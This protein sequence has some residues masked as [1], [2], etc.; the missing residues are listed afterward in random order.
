MAKSQKRSPAAIAQELAGSLDLSDSSFVSAE[1]AGPYV[2]LRL[3]RNRLINR[4]LSEEPVFEQR[5]GTV[6]VDYSAPNIAKPIGIGHLRSTVIGG[7]LVRIFRRLGMTV[8]GVN[9]LGDW[10]T[11]FG[12]LI[13]A[14]RKW[15][16]EEELA[17]APIKHLH[18][19][20]VRFHKEAE[21]DETLEQ[22]GRDAFKQLED[23]NADCRTLW[24]RFR[25]ASLVE[26]EK[27][28]RQLGVSF[29]V[30]TGEAAYQDK[31]Q[32]AIAACAGIASESDGALVV[33]LDG[34][35]PLL[36]R[37][38]DGATLYATRDLAAALDR[39]ATYHPDSLLYVVGQEQQLHFAQL[40][41]VLG[42][43]G[44]DGVGEHVS[45]GLYRFADGKMSTR[46]GKSVLMEDVL[47]KAVAL[48]REV[49]EQKNPSLADKETVA[50]QVG[51]GAVIF[52]DLS[53]DRARDVVFDWDKVLDFS[54]ESGPY[55][56]YTHARIRSVLRKAGS[57]GAVGDASLGEEEFRLARLLAAFPSRVTEA[58]DARKP[59][60][61]CRYLL[62]LCQQYNQ[63]YQNVRIIGSEQEQ[64]RLAL[65]AKTADVLAQGLSL[66]GIA[67]PE[68]M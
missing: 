26:F 18:A 12:K 2:N 10:G 4:V 58:A 3:D 67:A 8:V 31:A 54:G 14:W 46:K 49:I 13:V 45:F 23:G 22:Q 53:T 33:E 27:T 28:Y 20:Y 30:V 40:F 11:Q 51:V 56:Q 61:I 25:A 59:H 15:G 50:Q 38:S 68:E 42:K 9:Y 52:A 63:F 24:E 34:M 7:A 57:D 29:D 60:I 62:D 5:S 64:P 65:C 39:I 1:A 6:V 36:L 55:V 32:E 41:T 37:K 44:F 17:A 35:P 66:L 19:L 43:L 21:D 16:S 47:D 48:V